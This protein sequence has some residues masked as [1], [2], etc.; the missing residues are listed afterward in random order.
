MDRLEK[1]FR[2]VRDRDVRV[3]YKPHI[4]A[5][6]ETIHGEIVEVQKNYVKILVPVPTFTI[7]KDKTH[8]VV[9]IPFRCIDKVEYWP[10]KN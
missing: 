6:T 8:F 4:R 10:R 7:T 5:T 2:A 3:T 1:F 9:P